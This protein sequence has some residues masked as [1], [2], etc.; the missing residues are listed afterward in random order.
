M[1]KNRAI[2]WQ[3]AS[4][5]VAV[6]AIFLAALP[7]KAEPFAR[8][9]V[10]NIS[11]TLHKDECRLKSEITNLPKRAVWLEDGKETEGCW[12]VL[13]QFGIVGLYFAD[14]TATALPVQVFERVTGA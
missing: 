12:G 14:K 9:A 5:R 2:N 6:L 1:T 3:R 10:A 7:L 4:C 8:F 11:I 13:G